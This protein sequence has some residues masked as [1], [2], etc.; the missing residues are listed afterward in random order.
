[1]VALVPKCLVCLATYVGL[2]ALL[3][4][5]FAGTELCGAT[6]GN[7]LRADAW[8][9]IGGLLVVA[10]V[11]SRWVFHRCTHRHLCE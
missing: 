2:G 5:R 3:G 11:F 9:A 6:T 8:L 7:E 4:I 10:L 1:M